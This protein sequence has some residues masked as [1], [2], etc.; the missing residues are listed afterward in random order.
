MG[1]HTAWLLAEHLS[2][3][4]PVL[5]GA[6]RVLLIESAAAIG[7][8]P[9]HRQK[10]L[11]LLSAIRRTAERLRD[12]GFEVDLRPAP[13]YAAGVA[14]HRAAHGGPEVRLLRPLGHG[15]AG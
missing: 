12:A 5:R 3:G 11:L 2:P 8:A 14:A 9:H 4:N 1:G 10:L 6:G 13:T 7:G 15:A